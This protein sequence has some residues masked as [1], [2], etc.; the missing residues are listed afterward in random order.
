[1]HADR[2]AKADEFWFVTDV[3]SP[4]VDLTDPAEFADHVV[5]GSTTGDK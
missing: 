5:P 4:L 1:M 2:I 3:D